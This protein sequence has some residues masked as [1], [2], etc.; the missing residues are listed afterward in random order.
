MTAIRAQSDQQF[1]QSPR[2]TANR[3]LTA[4]TKA[5][6]QDKHGF[7]SSGLTVMT[8]LA[9]LLTLGAAATLHMTG[10]PPWFLGTAA[11]ALMVALLL[12]GRFNIKRQW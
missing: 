4:G 12:P 8:T 6:G 2:F 5:A 7:G 10:Q 9:Y 1:T 3:I 11:V